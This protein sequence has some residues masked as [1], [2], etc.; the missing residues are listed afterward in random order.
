MPITWFAS[1]PSREMVPE[2]AAIAN[3]AVPHYIAAIR[4]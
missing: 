2:G 1:F 3:A 4:D